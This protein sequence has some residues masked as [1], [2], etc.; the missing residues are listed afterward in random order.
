M[1][2]RP[3]YPTPR[4]PRYSREQGRPPN[5][6]LVFRGVRSAADTPV[7]SRKR[8]TLT[9]SCPGTKTADLAMSG[10]ERG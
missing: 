3:T 7:S 10:H 1:R 9:V 6:G 4:L 5:H 8:F 2:R